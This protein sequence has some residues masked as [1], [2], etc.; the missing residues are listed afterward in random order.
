MITNKKK[1]IIYMILTIFAVMIIIP[2]LWMIFVA[3]TSSDLKSSLGIKVFIENFNIN[4]FKKLFIDYKIVRFFLNS[5]WISVITTLGQVFVCALSGFIFARANFKF[6]NTIFMIYL[7][8]MMIPIQA[9]IIPQYIIINKMGL[10][11]TYTALILPGLFSAFGTF[12]MKQYFAAVPQSIEEAAFIDG[13]SPFRIFFQI[14]LPLVKPGLAVLT[15][16]SFMSSWNDF[17]WPLLVAS[18]EAHMTLPVFLSQLQGM[19]YVDYS[20][21]MGATLIS[22]VPILILYLVA[23]KQFIE[24]VASSGVK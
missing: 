3:F 10:V 20:L 8:T 12:L 4:N 2:F 22:V 6:K 11:N 7:M 5:V 16:M 9:T 14:I 23:Q 1:Y 21:L 18:D 15:V 13:A 24:S 17:L 19:W